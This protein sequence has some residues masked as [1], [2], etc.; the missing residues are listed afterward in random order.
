MH[1]ERFLDKQQR[2]NTHTTLLFCVIDE[3]RFRLAVSACRFS[4]S[5]FEME[6]RGPR[7]R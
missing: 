6:K 3:K 2:E 5:S 1:K 4:Y 7:F